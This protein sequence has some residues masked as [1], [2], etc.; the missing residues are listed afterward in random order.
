LFLELKIIRKK[1]WWPDTEI[2]D[3]MTLSKKKKRFLNGWSRAINSLDPEKRHPQRDVGVAVASAGTS[4]L[5]A[6]PQ[7]RILGLAV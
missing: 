4:C 2:F 5:R 6:L 3:D 7:S 1:F